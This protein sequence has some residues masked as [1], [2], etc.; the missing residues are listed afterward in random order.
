VGSPL[1]DPRQ[2]HSVNDPPMI[3]LRVSEATAAREG[4][5]QVTTPDSGAVLVDRTSNPLQAAAAALKILGYGPR[6][7]VECMLP[8]SAITKDL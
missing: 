5:Y 7:L 6:V 4:V 1:R 2:G 3:R 8:L